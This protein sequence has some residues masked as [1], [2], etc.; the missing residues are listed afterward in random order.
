[1]GNLDMPLLGNVSTNVR[2]HICGLRNS[3]SLRENLRTVRTQ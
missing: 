2:L 1:M 3:R